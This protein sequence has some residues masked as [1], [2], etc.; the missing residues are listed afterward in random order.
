[1]DDLISQELE[2]EFLNISSPSSRIPTTEPRVII[3]SRKRQRQGDLLGEALVRATKAELL[4]EKK[5]KIENS[6]QLNEDRHFF[7]SLMP[8]IQKMDPLTK[9]AI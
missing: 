7:E 3:P 8:H 6:Y 1:M 9:I 2:G 5:S 4:Q